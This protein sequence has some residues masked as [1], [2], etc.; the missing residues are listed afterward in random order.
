MSGYGKETTG[1]PDS[2][3]ARKTEK[4]S[5]GVGDTTRETEKASLG[6]G[7]AGNERARGGSVGGRGL[8]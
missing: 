2:P 1:K 6:A 7:V 5:L 3:G 4:A 8:L